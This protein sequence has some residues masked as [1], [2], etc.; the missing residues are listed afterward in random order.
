MNNNKSTKLTTAA[1]VLLCGVG[2]IIWGGVIKGQVSS[3][4]ARIAQVQRG[5]DTASEVLSVMPETAPVGSAVSSYA[6]GQ[7]NEKRQEASGYAT[8][9]NWMLTVGIVVSALSALY[10]LF[11][12][13]KK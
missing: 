2:L 8:L 7:L 12:F 9:A 1:I 4:R 3:G 13:F 5:V 6:D 11:L 10:I